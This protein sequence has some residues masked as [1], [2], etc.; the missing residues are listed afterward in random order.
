[1]AGR[2][3]NEITTD[4]LVLCLDAWNSKSYEGS[5]DTWVDLGSKNDATLENSPGFSNNF[6]GFTSASKRCNLN[7]TKNNESFCYEIVLKPKNL[8]GTQVYI[9][10]Y[11]GT[12]VGVWVGLTGGKFVFSINGGILNSNVSAVLDSVYHIICENSVGNGQRIFI[13]GDLKNSGSYTS[14]SPVGNIKIGAFGDANSYQSNIEVSLF[15]LYDKKI[16][17]E[18]ALQNYNALK[19]RFGL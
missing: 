3:L 8:S 4:G 18:G 13:N 5:G 10:K 12:G 1:M 7:Y 15:R 19:G 17:T 14:T 6:I 9:G 16:S 2:V 11:N